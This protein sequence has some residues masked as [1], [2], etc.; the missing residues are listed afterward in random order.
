VGAVPGE[1]DQQRI[2]R[3]NQVI[4]QIGQEF[5]TS[6]ASI[7]NG[8][9]PPEELQKKLSPDT[10]Q[11]GLA[12]LQQ[13]FTSQPTAA[14]QGALLN[15]YVDAAKQLGDFSRGRLQEVTDKSRS[16]YPYAEKYFPDRMDKI[17]QPL[18]TP[19]VGGNQQ[20]GTAA[21]S[22]APTPSVSTAPANSIKM[23]FNG[24]T[25]WIPASMKGAAISD[26]WDV[27]K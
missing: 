1:T 26:G 23:T 27:V 13:K 3:L 7:M 19:T 10:L 14:N 22:Q 5:S 9:V 2:Q 16:A 8:G 4:P 18:A 24:K 21:Q 25:K 6:L 20:A 12:S 15:A 17:A 11:S